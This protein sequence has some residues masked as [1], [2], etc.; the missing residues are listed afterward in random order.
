MQ[1]R[2]RDI[3]GMLVPKRLC[4]RPVN[5]DR[6]RMFIWE[7][8]GRTGSQGLIHNYR[9][10]FHFLN[11]QGTNTTARRFGNRVSKNPRNSN[12]LKMVH[13]LYILDALRR[14]L[15][16][17]SQTGQFL[18]RSEF[19]SWVENVWNLY[20]TGYGRQWMKQMS[21]KQYINLSANKKN[22][23]NFSNGREMISQKSRNTDENNAVLHRKKKRTKSWS[24]S[25]VNY[26]WVL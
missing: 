1:N 8:Y 5:I 14:T 25:G 13:H 16:R 3:M 22:I 10:P 19:W 7:E 2:K 11:V 15:E 26:L 4:G 24:C 9:N 18:F 6:A 12:T 21:E 23:S 20:C 17:Y